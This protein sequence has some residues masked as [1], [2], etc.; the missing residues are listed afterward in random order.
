MT[1]HVLKA[2]NGATRAGV[3]RIDWEL[4]VAAAESRVALDDAVNVNSESLDEV[5]HPSDVGFQQDWEKC[6]KLRKRQAASDRSDVIFGWLIVAAFTAIFSVLLVLTLNGPGVQ[7]PVPEAIVW[8]L[9]GA[10][11]V[12]LGA[13]KCTKLLI[14][15]LRERSLGHVTRF[16]ERNR[17][18]AY[19]AWGLTNEALYIV[20][21]DDGADTLTVDRIAYKNIQACAHRNVDGAIFADVYDTNGSFYTIL[22]PVNEN[23]HTAQDLAAAVNERVAAVDFS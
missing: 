7:N 23:I 22:S 19:Q 1:I 21:R 13:Y 20:K 14:G 15:Y 5:V 8:S 6:A 4:E 17:C 16:V 3:E 11:I 2:F 9:V 18:R 10:T 12:G